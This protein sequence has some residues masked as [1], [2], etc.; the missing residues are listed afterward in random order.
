MLPNKQRVIDIT[1]VPDLRQ[2]LEE[3]KRMRRSYILRAEGQDVGILMPTRSARKRRAKGK[4]FTK[5]DPLWGI[6]GMF[7][8]NGG[9]TDIST[10]SDKYLAEAYTELHE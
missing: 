10:H 7:K 3:I 6:V 8:D 4:V 5:N 1:T 9:P 2:I